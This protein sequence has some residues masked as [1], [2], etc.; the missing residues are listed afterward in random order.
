MKYNI[1]RIKCAKKKNDAL[2]I[3]FNIIILIITYA[4][5]S[6]NNGRLIYCEQT[7]LLQ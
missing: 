2:F 4:G 3:K 5:L 6:D 1:I 7:M